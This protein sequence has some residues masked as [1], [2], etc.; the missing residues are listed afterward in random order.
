MY[1]TD[2]SPLPLRLRRH[3]FIIVFVHTFETSNGSV[4]APGEN[5][6]L[7]QPD[8]T[9]ERNSCPITGHWPLHGK[10]SNYVCAV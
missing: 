7:Q 2:F 5:I 4:V 10:G 8:G 1:K 6:S 9:F 3:A